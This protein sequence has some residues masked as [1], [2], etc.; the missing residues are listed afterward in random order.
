MH[1]KL[2]VNDD[3]S[4]AKLFFFS[5]LF[6]SFYVN[7]P[8]V[9]YNNNIH[10]DCTSDMTLLPEDKAK[11]INLTI[12]HCSFLQLFALVLEDVKLC[13]RKT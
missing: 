13:S 7:L 12:T 9:C 3:K 11:T 2:T 10:C 5:F 4:S 1:G 6:L 8:D